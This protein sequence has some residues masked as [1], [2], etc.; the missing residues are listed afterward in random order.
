MTR[1]SLRILALSLILSI[2]A[3]APGSSEPSR[4]ES[5]QESTQPEKLYTEAEALAAARISAQTAVDVAVPLAVR[6]AVAQKEGELAASRALETWARAEERRHRLR[7]GAWRCFALAAAGGLAG[8]LADRDSLG[9]VG[10]GAAAGAALGVVWQG[11][12]LLLLGLS[13]A[14]N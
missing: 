12:E 9:G 2:L 11:L 8:A 10:G 6:E 5:T 4:Q 1:S 3:L 14:A 13:R 7:A